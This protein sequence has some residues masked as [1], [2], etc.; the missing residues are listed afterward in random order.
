MQ[1]SSSV[2]PAEGRSAKRKFDDISNFETKFSQRVAGKSI[3]DLYAVEVYSGTAGLT[4]ALRRVGLVHSLG[5]DA[6]ITKQ[7]KAPVVRLDLTTS[8]G[9]ELLW[10]ILQHPRV[11]FV[12][13]GP[14]CGTSSRARD[15]RRK[16]RPDPKP[17]RS[18]QF[19]DGLPTLQGVSAKRV[20]AAN[21]LYSLAGQFFFLVHIAWHSMYIGKPSSLLYVGND[22]SFSTP[23]IAT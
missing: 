1:A 12:H 21:Q 17:L 16:K 2:G 5:V 10:K 6:Y 8:S 9:V 7:V 3:T 20:Q 18:A 13:L 4:A 14:P 23:W 15:I 11:A 19:P 22:A